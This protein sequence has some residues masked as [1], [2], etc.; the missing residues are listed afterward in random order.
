MSKHT[1]NGSNKQVIKT[2]GFRARVTT[3]SGKAILKRRRRWG[4]WKLTIGK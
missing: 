3:K 1:C 4:C 2:S